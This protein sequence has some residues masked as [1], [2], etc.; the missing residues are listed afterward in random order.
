M[1]MYVWLQ[2]WDES[3]LETGPA[4]FFFPVAWVYDIGTTCGPM[5][6]ITLIC[7][8]NFFANTYTLLTNVQNFQ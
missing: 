4:R 2:M 3:E 7:S 1:R 6:K 8:S 5:N